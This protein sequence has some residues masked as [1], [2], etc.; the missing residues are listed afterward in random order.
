MKTD[1][2]SKTTRRLI[3]S[4]ALM[5]ILIATTIPSAFANSPSGNTVPNTVTAGVTPV[6]L[7]L[8]SNGVLQ[9]NFGEIRVFDKNITP[10]GF[11]AQASTTDCSLPPTLLVTDKAWDLVTSPG[12]VQ[13]KYTIPIGGSIKIPFGT[14]ASFSVTLLGGSTLSVAGPYIWKEVNAPFSTGTDSISTTVGD[15][16]EW[17]SCGFDG[18][19]TLQ[20]KMSNTF[21]IVAPVGGSIIPIDTTALLVAGVASTGLWWMIPVLGAAGLAVFTIRKQFA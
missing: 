7:V 21:Q 17:P 19:A 8:T 15:T 5:V 1:Y 6:T 11:P 10:G 18:S 13:V 3:P 14:G 9:H 2:T 4:I 16:Y 12:G 20:Y